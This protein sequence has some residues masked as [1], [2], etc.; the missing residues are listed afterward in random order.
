[1]YN[2]FLSFYLSFK[3]CRNVKKVSLF[4]QYK[5][6]SYTHEYFLQ[7]LKLMFAIKK[8]TLFSATIKV[9]K[10]KSANPKHYY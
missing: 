6:K 10:R 1:M 4:I 5:K 8:M 9:N 3:E 2:L 7:C